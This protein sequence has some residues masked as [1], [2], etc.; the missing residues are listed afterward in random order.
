LLP[1][2]LQA[3]DS[4]TGQ[5][6]GEFAMPGSLNSSATIVGNMIFVGTGNSFDGGGSSVQAFVLP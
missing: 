6:V 3:F 4:A 5:I 2:A 1:P